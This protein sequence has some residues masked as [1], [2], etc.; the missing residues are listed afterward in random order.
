MKKLTEE[1]LEKLDI[2]LSEIESDFF[3]KPLSSFDKIYGDLDVDY[4]NVK[5]MSDKGL[6]DE[7]AA[8]SFEIWMKNNNVEYRRF[9]YRH[10]RI[11]S[12]S[13]FNALNK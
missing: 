8:D 11:T 7:T 2:L 3:E 12:V 4:C 13:L 6:K 10:F 5:T 1:Q 9:S